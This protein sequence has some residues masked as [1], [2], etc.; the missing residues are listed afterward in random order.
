MTRIAWLLLALSLP[1]W[2]TINGV[3]SSRV[4]LPAPDGYRYAE[5]PDGDT[6]LPPSGL[7]YENVFDGNPTNTADDVRQE[8]D[9]TSYGNIGILANQTDTDYDPNSIM[10][11]GLK[12]GTAAREWDGPDLFIEDESGN[13]VLRFDFDAS[14]NGYNLTCA[15]TLKHRT[16][17]ILGL[18]VNNDTPIV[19]RETGGEGFRVVPDEDYWFGFKYKMSCTGDL[20]ANYFMFAPASNQPA[21]PS[22]KM[23][24]DCKKLILLQERYR[25]A[26]GATQQVSTTTEA[27]AKDTWHCV[28]IHW[29]KKPYSLGGAGG[30]VSGT[31]GGTR[32]GTWE[33]W[34]N[35]AL[36]DGAY[37]ATN[38]YGF[39][40][41]DHKAE[42]RLNSRYRIGIY[43]GTENNSTTG[44]MYI[45][46][47]RIGE[48]ASL[49]DSVNGDSCP[50]QIP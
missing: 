26:A 14:A 49:F 18:N 31:V 43:W 44:S 46:D 40:G 47:V 8:T 21:E 39:T 35:G 3:D 4:V 11:D 15:A 38:G 33:T 20:P 36:Q 34:V 48:G 37:N 9:A 50:A 32:A 19:S 27:F 42:G 12:C 29:I 30:Y 23:S 45:D 22:I 7:L 13:K 2:A 41:T 5:Y 24:S 17:L 28:V 1:A 10:W 25:D 6:P 16:Q